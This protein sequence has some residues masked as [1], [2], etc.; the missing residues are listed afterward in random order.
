MLIVQQLGIITSFHLFSVLTMRPHTNR[1]V[2]ISCRNDTICFQTFSHEYMILFTVVALVTYYCYYWQWPN[3]RCPCY[4]RLK[5]YVVVM[6][7]RGSPYLDGGTDNLFQ[8]ITSNRQFFLFLSQSTSFSV[9]NTVMRGVGLNPDE[10]I[11]SNIRLTVVVRK[12]KEEEI[13]LS[14]MN[15]TCDSIRKFL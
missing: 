14:T 11:P 12:I 9:I 10:S 15:N 13:I 4:D 6:P 8:H 5:I 3:F 1:N 7:F 2:W